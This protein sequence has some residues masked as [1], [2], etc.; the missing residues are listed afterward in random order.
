MYLPGDTLLITDVGVLNYITGPGRS[1]VCVTSN[2]N[3]QCCRGSDG[4]NVGEWF[5]PDGSIVPRYSYEYNFS[6]SGYTHQVRLN[7][8]N[9]AMGPIGPY[10]CRVPDD[11]G[12]LQTANIVLTTPGIPE[13]DIILCS[14]NTTFMIII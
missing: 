6:R 13:V 8:R 3:T 4:G 10:E 7:R 2:V 14:C 1:L 11:S 12:V 5:F 9:N